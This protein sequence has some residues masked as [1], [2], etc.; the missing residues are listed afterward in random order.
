MNV[1]NQDTGVSDLRNV[2]CL[3]C[4][5]V[6]AAGHSG[7]SLAEKRGCPRCGYVGWRAAGAVE[8]ARREPNHVGDEPSR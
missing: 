3:A 4:G 1:E 2:R 7:R 6:Y 8:E 5:T